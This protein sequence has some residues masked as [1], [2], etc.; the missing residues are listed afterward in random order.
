MGELDGAMRSAVENGFAFVDRLAFIHVTRPRIFHPSL[1]FTTSSSYLLIYE[2]HPDLPTGEPWPLIRP[3][4][5]LTLPVKDESSF[6]RLQDVLPRKSVVS[7]ELLMSLTEARARAVLMA[8]VHAMQRHPDVIMD[9]LV[10]HTHGYL[11]QRFTA[12]GYGVVHVSN[13]SMS[14]MAVSLDQLLEEAVREAGPGSG[15]THIDMVSGFYLKAIP[16]AMH[17]AVQVVSTWE[18]IENIRD[19]TDM[20]PPQC[21]S[22]LCLQSISSW[23]IHVLRDCFRED[24][25]PFEMDR[26]VRVLTFLA[27][28]VENQNANVPWEVPVS[29]PCSDEEVEQ[30]L[31]NPNAAITTADT[32]GFI[33]RGD[34]DYFEKVW[35]FIAH[36]AASLSSVISIVQSLGDILGQGSILPLIDPANPSTLARY[37]NHLVQQMQANAAS[38]QQPR[39]STSPPVALHHGPTAYLQYALEIGLFKVQRDLLQWMAQH[40][41]DVAD[42]ETYLATTPSMSTPP[43]ARLKHLQAIVHLC[44]VGKSLG[45]NPT[46]LRQVT[47]LAMNHLKTASSN[48]PTLHIPLETFLP[49]RLRSSLSEASFR[50]L[51]ITV[52]DTFAR[53]VRIADTQPDPTQLKVPAELA[54]WIQKKAPQLSPD[55]VEILTNASIAFDDEGMAGTRQLVTDGR[56]RFMK[57]RQ[58]K[59]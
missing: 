18:G 2:L 43:V 4:S 23:D 13:P 52:N 39:S 17:D 14:P 50:Q 12:D 37:F 34:L 59:I 20:P 51:T 29:A 45:L 53:V 38:P 42:V 3:A 19:I 33:Q 49:E 26:N 22:I 16:I 58:P 31:L 55:A 40:G 28:G 44:C 56:R 46:T 48:L 9:V 47:G 35:H 54:S 21:T 30:Y 25:F 10:G 57:Y 11:G 8:T 6:R 7:S 32:K 5:V 36:R 15:L 24:A 27:K 41:Y 1:A